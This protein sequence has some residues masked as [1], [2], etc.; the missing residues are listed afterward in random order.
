MVIT[1]SYFRRSPT[2]QTLNDAF[3]QVRAD[4][5][6]Q[7]PRSGINVPTI[8]RCPSKNRAGIGFVQVSG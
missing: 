3:G 4:A 6:N 8:G 2:R 1:Q 5:Q 7:Q